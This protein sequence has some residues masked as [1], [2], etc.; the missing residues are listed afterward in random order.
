L[1]AGNE[2]GLQEL[3]TYLQSYLIETKAN[4]M[5]LN[6]NSIYQTILENDSFLELQEFCINLISKES[7][8]IF[9][10]QNFSSIPEKLLISLVQSDN[11]QMNEI[12]V[13]EH[14]LKWGLAQN[15]KL[16]SN[17][18]VFKKEDFNTL[19]NILQQ[20]I[21]FIRFYNLTSEE[22]SDK[23][24][25]YKKIL[26]KELYKDLLEYFLDPNNQSSKKS[27][28]HK[29]TQKTSSKK[30]KIG[31]QDGFI[32]SDKIQE[33]LQNIMNDMNVRDIFFGKDDV[34]LN[35]NQKLYIIV[36]NIP[37]NPLRMVENF[38]IDGEHFLK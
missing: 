27:E 17:P 7:D 23:V 19:K 24:L 12:Q 31:D 1:V 26:P 36:N 22:F 6:F 20:C 11:L 8:K 37:T 25:P 18:A 32:I 38:P 35:N 10:S 16:P 34:S 29:V 14:V 4:W 15:P 2:L 3:I 28:S 33:E 9:K 5:D 13:W 30:E 21:P